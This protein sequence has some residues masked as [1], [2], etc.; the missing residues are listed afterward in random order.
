MTLLDTHV[1]VWLYEDP[2]RLLP[3]KVR[4]RLESDVLVLSP[5]VG[6]ELQYLHE[7]G[8]IEVPGKTVIGQLVPKLEMIVSDP[9]AALICDV[10]ATLNWTRDPFDRLISAHAAATAM[11]LITKDRTIRKQLPQAWWP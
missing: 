1:V 2:E 7:V 3:A 4:R 11:P 9:P 8:R 10:A 5:F 6:L